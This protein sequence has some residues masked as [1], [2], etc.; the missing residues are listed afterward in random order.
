MH[1]A[2]AKPTAHRHRL[3]THRTAAEVAAA[4]TLTHEEARALAKAEAKKQRR[5]ARERL[6]ELVPKA[7]G[8]EG[9][10][11]ARIA[12]REDART[13]DISPD[14]VVTGGGNVMGGTDSFAAALARQKRQQ[15]ARTQRMVRAR[16][17]TVSSR[18]YLRVWR[19]VGAWRVT[20]RGA[21]SFCAGAATS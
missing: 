8:R 21:C 1:V 7:T 10:V 4:E 20:L 9:K 15:D 14:A 3:S 16:C 12:R 18:A 17:I 11:E 6:D 5:E 2:F 19:L 13:R